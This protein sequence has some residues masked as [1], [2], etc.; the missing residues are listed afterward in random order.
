MK[1]TMPYLLLSLCGLLLACASEQA[2]TAPPP[3]AEPA[4]KAP[5]K[6]S[7]SAAANAKTEPTE[8]AVKEAAPPAPPVARTSAQS[9]ADKAAAALTKAAKDKQ[10]HAQVNANGVSLA[11]CRTI[12]AHVLLLSLQA[13]PADATTEIREQHTAKLAKECPAGCMRHAT[14]AS[15]NCVL[16]AKSAQQA[17]ACQP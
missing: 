9:S 2:T 10:A 3:Q 5:S 16:R 12:C 7:P 1:R 17:A 13:L 4:A 6:V 11:A 8:L 14:P 15:N